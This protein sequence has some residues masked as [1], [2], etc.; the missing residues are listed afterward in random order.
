MTSIIGKFLSCHLLKECP[1]LPTGMGECLGS[2]CD[3]EV[4]GRASLSPTH[5][6][7][8]WRWRHAK[9]EI[10]FLLLLG[11]KVSLRNEIIC[12][13][14]GSTV[15]VQT[16]ILFSCVL[17][18]VETQPAL[19][20]PATVFPLRSQRASNM[21]LWLQDVLFAFL[22][23]AEPSNPSWSGENERSKKSWW[24]WADGEGMIWGE[25]MFCY[26][27]PSHSSESL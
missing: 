15:P 22:S 5:S 19:V 14:C 25:F 21:K 9:K 23:G 3:A 26:G 12:L 7:R 4:W 2:L 10:S 13:K 16:K 24:P 1:S 18:A 20:V 8:G 17:A 27:F 6:T 11:S